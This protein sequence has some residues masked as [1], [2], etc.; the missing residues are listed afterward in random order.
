MKIT[1]FIKN[2]EHDNIKTLLDKSTLNTSSFLSYHEFDSQ[3]L[4]QKLTSKHQLYVDKTN[5][6]K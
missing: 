3:T 5:N 2:K 1:I 6:T 4:I